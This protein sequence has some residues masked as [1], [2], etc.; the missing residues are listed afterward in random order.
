MKLL[1]VAYSGYAIK[2][3]VFYS[4]SC[5]QKKDS[6]FIDVPMAQRRQNI[7]D[8]ALLRTFCHFFW[9]VTSFEITKDIYVRGIS[10]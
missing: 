9:P 3:L 5:R 1:R 7:D 4:S 6:R 8:T 10:E 2:I